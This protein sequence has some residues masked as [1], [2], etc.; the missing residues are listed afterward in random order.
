M[1]EPGKSQYALT[2]PVRNSPKLESIRTD[3][4]LY[5]GFGVL[6]LV[7]GGLHCIA[8]DA[9]S[10]TPREQLLWRISSVAISANGILLLLIYTWELSPLIINMSGWL[11]KSREVH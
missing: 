6:G 9:L 2:D 1:P 7:Y 11:G 10:Q 5:L 4:K 3:W 8:W